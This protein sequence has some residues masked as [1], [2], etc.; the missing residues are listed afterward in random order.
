VAAT[1]V[2]ADLKSELAS[3]FKKIGEKASTAR[4]LEELYDFSRAHPDVDI[5]P[6]LSRT[7]GAFQMYIKR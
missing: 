6:H 3:I 4:G 5:Q 1:P 7:S 2:S